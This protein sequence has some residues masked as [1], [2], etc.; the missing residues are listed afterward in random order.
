[1]YR[2]YCIKNSYMFRKFTVAIFRL[3]NEKL[4]KQLY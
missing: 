4:R 1:M 3:R 2:I